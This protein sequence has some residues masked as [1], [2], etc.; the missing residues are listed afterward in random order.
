M[1]RHAMTIERMR[2]EV[3]KVKKLTN[4]TFAVNIIPTNDGDDGHTKPLIKMMIEEGVPAAV[5]TGSEVYPGIF[6]LLRERLSIGRKNRRRRMP[7]QPRQTGA[8]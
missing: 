2:N 3:R 6:R 1:K 4:G 8:P 5:Y 7:G